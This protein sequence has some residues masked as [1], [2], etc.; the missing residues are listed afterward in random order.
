M[1]VQY[2]R[3]DVHHQRAHAAYALTALLCRVNQS[4]H[5]YLCLVDVYYALIRIQD[6]QSH[7][8]AEIN[9]PLEIHSRFH[10]DAA[11]PR[12]AR[13]ATPRHANTR[14]L[15]HFFLIQLYIVR[16]LSYHSLMVQIK[17]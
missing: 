8:N 4:N 13:L 12:Y 6:F 9:L 5:G 1:H 14:D 2:L 3:V 17:R 11:V 7:L 15:V 16:S 10:A